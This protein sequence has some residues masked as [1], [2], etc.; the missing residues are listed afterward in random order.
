MARHWMAAMALFGGLAA[1]PQVMAAEL[2]ADYL[3]GRWSTG[4]VEDCKNAEHE[5]TVYRED[6]PSPPSIQTRRWPSASGR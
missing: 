4:S 6:D 3:H 2:T 5:Q 1:A